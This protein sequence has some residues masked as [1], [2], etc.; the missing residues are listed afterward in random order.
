M[1]T[2]F[3]YTSPVVFQRSFRLSATDRGKRS[4]VHRV[5]S[6][7]GD[8]VSVKDFDACTEVVKESAFAVG[9]HCVVV[10][11]Q[12]QETEKLAIE[13]AFA[14]GN[15]CVDVEFLQETEDAVG[16]VV[17]VDDVQQVTADEA[18]N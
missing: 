14:A 18:E 1:T 2:I 4:V 8:F 7:Q 16:M 13:T 10:D 11:M 9:N 17:P 5:V 3:H 12:N 15:H 6:C